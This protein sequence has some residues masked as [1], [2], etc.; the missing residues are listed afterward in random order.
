MT[1]KIN[2]KPIK[3]YFDSIKI[4]FK[5]IK[6]CMPGKIETNSRK[7]GEMLLLFNKWRII[8]D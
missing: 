6:R 7:R 1:V 4:N 3:K 8:H 5:P 2:L